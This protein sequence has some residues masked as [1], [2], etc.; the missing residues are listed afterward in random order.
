MLTIVGGI[1]E[2]NLVC[3]AAAESYTFSINVQQN[4]LMAVSSGTRSVRRSAAI[5]EVGLEQ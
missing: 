3:V 5:A 1:G 2:L 4:V